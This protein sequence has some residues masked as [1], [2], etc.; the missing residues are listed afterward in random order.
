VASAPAVA[1]NE[2]AE[3]EHTPEPTR[4][5]DEADAAETS[6]SAELVAPRK[7]AVDEWDAWRLR[8]VER[9]AEVRPPAQRTSPG[10]AARKE[11]VE[12]GE[13]EDKE[14][15]EVRIDEVIEQFEEVVESN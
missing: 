5:F 1:A 9:I 8:A 4:A 12:E 13:E 7:R 3:T 2:R 10:L 6:I 15:I 14:V 11:K